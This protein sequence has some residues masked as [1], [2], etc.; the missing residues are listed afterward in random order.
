VTPAWA[1]HAALLRGRRPWTLIRA[2]HSLEPAVAL[3]AL[4]VLA[5]LM[6]SI[7]LIIC[8]LARRGPLVRHTRVGWRGGPLRVLKFRTMW[9]QDSPCSSLLAIEEV[10]GIVPARK[11]L[12]DPRVT[13]RFARWCRR[14]S[15]DELPQ[16]VN[17]ARGEMSFV[18][19]RP[20]TRAE[21]DSYYGK[22]ADEV[23]S[24]RPGLAGLWQIMGRNRLDY[25]QRRRLDVFLVRR[26]SIRLYA[27]IL[28]RTVPLI[29]IGEGAY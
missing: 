15:L 27:R 24:M 5:P 17:V 13:S 4:V 1:T 6:I 3:A 7:A 20:I 14:H 23:L 21:L 26:I 28:L 29:L 12:A 11:T 18:G 16:L 25:G 22:W 8:V 19:P 9:E 10:S 2:I